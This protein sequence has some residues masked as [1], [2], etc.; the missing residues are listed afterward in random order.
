MLWQ[1]GKRTHTSDGRPD[2]GVRPGL[3]LEGI[4]DQDADRGLREKVELQRD[5]QAVEKLSIAQPR[6]VHVADVVVARQQ[7]R[8]E[9]PGGLVRLVELSAGAQHLGD[10]SGITD[11]EGVELGTQRRVRRNDGGP[12]DEQRRK[13]VVVVSP[14]AHPARQVG[15]TELVWSEAADPAG[16]SDQRG[17]VLIE[18]LGEDRLLAL[19]ILIQRGPRDTGG[20]G[21]VLDRALVKALLEETAQCRFENLNAGARPVHRSSGSSVRSSL[22][23]SPDLS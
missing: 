1:R 4:A 16:D 5:D 17:A 15:K 6:P 19:E 23:G 14:V 9:H 13:P 22:A 18:Q 12:F 21:N 11:S 8:G 2:V 20:S 3:G 10:F 7:R